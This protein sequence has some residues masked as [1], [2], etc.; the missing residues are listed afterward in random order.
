MLQQLNFGDIIEQRIA[1]NNQSVLYTVIPR[2]SDKMESDG[3]EYFALEFQAKIP[4][5][6]YTVKPSLATKAEL[7]Q[8]TYRIETVMAF[9]QKNLE[10]NEPMHSQKYV[11]TQLDELERMDQ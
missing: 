6:E 1:R 2:T 9:L 11:K 4:A 3:I 8:K 7:A 5:I 10:P